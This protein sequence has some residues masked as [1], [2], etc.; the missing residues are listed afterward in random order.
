VF[1]ANV[2]KNLKSY[3]Y[4]YVDPRTES[5]FY[6]GQG[7]GNRAF[8]HLKEIADTPKVQIIKELGKLGIKPEIVVLRHGLDSEE[9]KLVESVCIDF[10]GLDN[11]SNAVKGKHSRLFGRA[12]IEEIVRRYD[13]TPCQPTEPCIAI[14]VNQSYQ[15][16][17]TER[18]L[19]ECTRGIWPLAEK[20]SL[21]RYALAVFEEVILEVYRI[22]GWFPAG[23]IYSER[24]FGVSERYE[25]VGNIDV[26]LSSKYKGKSL[27]SMFSDG[28]RFPVRYMNIIEA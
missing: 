25:F 5:A 28:K 6:V 21:A 18:E 13:A 17:M 1:S 2:V 23:K 15:P 4:A 7:K 10:M 8:S 27:P 26:E 14:N 20:R 9:A 12:S 22:E 24:L 11:L 3:V 19:Y 16:R